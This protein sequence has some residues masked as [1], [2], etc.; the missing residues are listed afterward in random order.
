[1]S[2]VLACLLKHT[3]CYKSSGKF[4]TG[5]T[6]LEPGFQYGICWHCLHGN[7]VQ[8]CLVLRASSLPG[9]ISHLPGSACRNRSS[10]LDEVAALHPADIVVCCLTSFCP[11]R[12]S[13]GAHG[14]PCTCRERRS[15]G[16]RADMWRQ[17]L[18]ILHRL[19]VLLGIALLIALGIWFMKV[20]PWC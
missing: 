3:A 9:P 7:S 6:R 16:G 4:I 19:F 20:Q 13:S 17:P 18:L 10:V 1:M 8:A 15:R 2:Q 14:R 5:R 11:H 12:L